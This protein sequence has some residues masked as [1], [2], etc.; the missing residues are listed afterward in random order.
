MGRA[1]TSLDTE[2]GECWN[3]VA[4]DLYFVGFA[5]LLERHL[6]TE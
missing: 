5:W 3:L 6:L 4:A 2:A 1:F